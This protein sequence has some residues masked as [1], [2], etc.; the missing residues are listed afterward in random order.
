MR[1]RFA[2]VEIASATTS[3]FGGVSVIVIESDNL[4]SKVLYELHRCIKM[5][6][7]QSL[8]MPTLT[9]PASVQT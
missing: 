9:L 6:F 1:E 4:Y 8:L 5:T 3:W 7:I 2:G